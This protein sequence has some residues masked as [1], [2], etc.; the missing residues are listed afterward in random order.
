MAYLRR[1]NKGWTGDA[2][3]MVIIEVLAVM[4]VM[5]MLLAII[6]TLFS[7]VYGVERSWSSAAV[8]GRELQ[9]LAAYFRED[10]H[11]AADIQIAD[12][13]RAWSL[14]LLN[15]RRA[16]YEVLRDAVSRTV[17]GSRDDPAPPVGRQ[18]LGLPA[19]AEINVQDRP[20]VGR[21]M[22]TLTVTAG[23]SDRG[24]RNVMFR[25]DAELRRLPAESQ[26]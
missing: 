25:V 26:P 23:S 7:A 5:A 9:R 14:S 18:E 22:V 21:R 8:E 3:G 13:G 2:S 15:G 12:D 24:D 10:A 16:E 11:R 20:F 6:V 1:R 4:A 17:R 19:G